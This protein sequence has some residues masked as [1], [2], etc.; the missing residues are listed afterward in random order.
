MTWGTIGNVVTTHLASDTDDP[1]LAR[2]TIYDAIV[3]LQ[4]VINGRAA[5]SGVAPLNASSKVDA[6]YLPDTITSSTS[7]DLTLAP[8]TGRVVIQDILALQPKSTVELEA[9]TGNAGDIAYCSDGDAGSAC[10]AVSL[11]E[12]DSN[13]SIWYRISL[14]TQ[15]SET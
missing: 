2:V 11:G 7:T 6:A 10:I 8:D 15:I 12:T 13:G 3:E 14:G 5:A 1:S 4:A 9:L